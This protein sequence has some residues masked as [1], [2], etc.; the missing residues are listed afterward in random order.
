MAKT[1][2]KRGSWWIDYSANGER[3]REPV[4]LSHSLAKEVL[5][6]RLAQVAEQKHFPGRVA[7]AKPFSEAAEKFWD[8]HG[9]HLKQTGLKGMFDEIKAVLGSKRLASVTAE[10]IQRHM[11]TVAAR[12]SN[13]TANRQLTVIKSI[14]NK[15]RTWGLY[16]GESPAA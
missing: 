13:A 15:A 2:R 7:N 12:A 4:G 3:H 10:D 5:A 16:H 6:K 8:L 9:Q 1:F 11:N 14:F